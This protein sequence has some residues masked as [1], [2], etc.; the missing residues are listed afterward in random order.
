MRY[1]SFSLTAIRK[2]LHDL[3][4]AD[5]PAYIACYC[6]FSRFGSSPYQCNILPVGCPFVKLFRQPVQRKLIFCYYEN[7]RSIFIYTMYKTRTQLSCLK[8]RQVLK[9]PHQGI[10]Q[11]ACI[12]TISRVNNHTGFF[13][14]NHDIF[15]LINNVNRNIFGNKFY[16]SGRS[17]QNNLDDICRL[18]FVVWLYGFIVY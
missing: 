15:I 8:Q 7:T 17:R 10:H 5:I 18:D 1:S 9:M 4:V 2:N 13:I 14:Y 11:C 3:S 6:S 16:I 12:I